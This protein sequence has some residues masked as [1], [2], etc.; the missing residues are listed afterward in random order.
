MV[1]NLKN[2]VV[3]NIEA[4]VPKYFKGDKDPTADAYRN[5]VH[6][7]DS[8]L[9]AYLTEAKKQLEFKNSMM[10]LEVS[11]SNCKNQA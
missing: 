3:K 5:C 6:Y 2:D 4:D 7:S 10:I 1:S 9:H 11:V 8:C